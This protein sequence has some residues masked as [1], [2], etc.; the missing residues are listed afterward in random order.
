LGKGEPLATLS[1]NDATIVNGYTTN[2]GRDHKLTCGRVQMNHILFGIKK[3]Y[4]Y[5]C[6]EPHI[7]D[8][9]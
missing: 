3:L 4:K 7:L 8:V 9:A 6:I 5:T 2:I 1:T